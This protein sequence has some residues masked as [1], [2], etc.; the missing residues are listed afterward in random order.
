M[1]MARKN[2]TSS[3]LCFLHHSE[4]LFPL[5]Q[6]TTNSF[7]PPPS[8]NWRQFL[9]CSLISISICNE[10]V[11]IFV[12]DILAKTWLVIYVV[13]SFLEY[14]CLFWKKLCSSI[15]DFSEPRP[16]PIITYSWKWKNSWSTSIFLLINT[17]R[18]LVYSR[19]YY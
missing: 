11:F 6:N 10:L 4:F 17:N 3:L 1:F 19:Q 7:I 9:R 12:V 5:W 15:F 18:C 13:T 2:F 16:M 14:S 8:F